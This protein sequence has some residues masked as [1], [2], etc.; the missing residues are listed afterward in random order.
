MSPPLPNAL[1]DGRPIVVAVAGPNGSGKSTVAPALLAETLGVT[2]FVNA[3]VIAQGLAGFSPDSAAIEAGRIMLRRIKSLAERRHTFAFETTLSSRTFAPWFRGQGESGYSI[4]VVFFWLP[5][6]ELAVGRV[7]ARVA[8][9]GHDVPEHVVRRRYRSSIQNFM[10]LYA[11][12]VD[13]WWLY[14]NEGSGQPHLVASKGEGAAPVVHDPTR[15]LAVQE[16][17]SA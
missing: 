12:Q 7:R 1:S 11:P 13:L 14:E 17:S 3:D 4:A 8:L 5:S 2:E 10:K 9:G 6:P 15:W 16:A